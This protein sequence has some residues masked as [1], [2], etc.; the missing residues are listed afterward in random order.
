M[1]RSLVC[2]T[3]SGNDVE[4]EIERFVVI[5]SEKAPVLSIEQM[6]SGKYR[7]YVNGDFK[8]ADLESIHIVR[9]D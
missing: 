1:K 9:E 4:F 5:K 2:K 7:L 3:K 6:A 8:I